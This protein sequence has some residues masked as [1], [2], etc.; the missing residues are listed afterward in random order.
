MREAALQRKCINIAHQRKVLTW[1]IA[2]V[3]KRGFPDVLMVTP[4]GV[5]ILI[6]FKTPAGRLSIAQKT[7]IAKLREAHILVYV[8][9]NVKY[10]KEILDE[11]ITQ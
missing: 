11:H 5:V 4:T 3:G 7:T 9:D 8:V 1:K 10:F 2:A 6:E